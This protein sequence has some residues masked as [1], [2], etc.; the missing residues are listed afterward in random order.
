MLVSFINLIFEDG[1]KLRF[2]LASSLTV[3][4]NDVLLQKITQRAPVIQSEFFQMNFAFVR[5]L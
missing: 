3:L 5:T 4:F 2:D 1:V